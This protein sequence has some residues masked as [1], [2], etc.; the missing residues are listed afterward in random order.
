VILSR[1]E[2]PWSTARRPYEQHR[3]LW[4][5]FPDHPAESR[6]QHEQERQGFLFRVEDIRP[7]RPARVLLQSATWPTPAAG[8]ALIG[9]REVDP[10]PCA[11]QRLAFLLTANPVKTIKDTQAADKPGKRRDTCRVPLIDDVEQAQ[12]LRRKLDGA[13]VVD[14]VSVLP[15]QPLFFQRGSRGGKLQIVTFEGV[16]TVVDPSRLC[17][18]LRNGIG[19]AKAFGCGLLLVRRA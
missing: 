3:S 16:L 5:L 7:G 17:S 11:G 18:L 14:A 4:K 2:I 10:K 19:P 6:Q 15:H 8:I 9:S 1:A 13:A 12:W